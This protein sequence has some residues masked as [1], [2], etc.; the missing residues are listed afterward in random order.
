MTFTELPSHLKAIREQ[1]K[2]EKGVIRMGWEES[3]TGPTLL[4][5][6]LIKCTGFTNRKS[7][8]HCRKAT[9][10]FV[11]KGRLGNMH[12]FPIS[13][14]GRKAPELV[15]HC[16]AQLPPVSFSPPPTY[17]GAK[18]EPFDKVLQGLH[19]TA[20][21]MVIATTNLQHPKKVMMYGSP[22]ELWWLGAPRLRLRTTYGEMM[23]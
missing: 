6:V 8:H 10:S 21:L 13:C 4:F 16:T 23:L 5:F 15:Q 17:V 18:G 19:Q 20:Q 1:W 3:N 9:Y 14:W 7:H 11:L 12:T 2:G 22:K